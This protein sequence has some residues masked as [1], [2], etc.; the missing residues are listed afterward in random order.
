MDRDVSLSIFVDELNTRLGF[1]RRSHT[2]D[3]SRRQHNNANFILIGHMAA[4]EE[5]CI[6]NQSE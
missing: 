1:A 2:T 6:S 3:H 4:W 5:S